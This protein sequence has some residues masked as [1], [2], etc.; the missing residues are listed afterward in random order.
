MFEIRPETLKRLREQY[1]EGCE[2]ELIEM[3]D[4]YRKMPAG[5]TGK[6]L[7]VDDIGSVHVAWSN[8][9]SLA[10]VYGEDKICRKL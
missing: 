9:S 8:G 4:P 5:L 7:F 6:V 3:N 1:P 2:V 10:A